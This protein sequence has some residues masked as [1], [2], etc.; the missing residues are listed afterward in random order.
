M[1]KKQ[2]DVLSPDGFSIS[3]SQTYSTPGEAYKATL[4]WAKRYES[5]GYYSSMDYGK[6]LVIDLPDFCKLIQVNQEGLMI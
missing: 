1:G 4:E 6:I 5:Q 2:F 3:P